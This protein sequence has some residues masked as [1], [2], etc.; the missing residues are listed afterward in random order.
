MIQL[1]VFRAIQGI[2]GGSILS[3]VLIIMSDVVTLRERGKYSGIIEVRVPSAFA[4]T[5]RL[6][7]LQGRDRAQQWRRPPPRRRLD[8]QSF[9]GQSLVPSMGRRAHDH[10]QRWCFYINLPMC[11][12]V[13][14][15][16]VFF[17]PQKRV[18]GDAKTAVP[19]SRDGAR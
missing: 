5:D 12:A 13:M 6:T 15:I 14:L 11:S 10:L 19:P 1:I 17:L 9:M 16:V 18:E 3:L 2:G 4:T 8:R 7:R